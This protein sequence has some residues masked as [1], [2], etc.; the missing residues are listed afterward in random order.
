MVDIKRLIEKGAADTGYITM[1]D[2]S[3]MPKRKSMVRGQI[4]LNNKLWTNAGKTNATSGL[5]YKSVAPDVVKKSIKIPKA[6][7][8]TGKVL[9]AGLTALWVGDSAKKIINYKSGNKPL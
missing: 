4:N 8:T 1:P 7:K 6:L 2:L 9:G 5:K 3:I